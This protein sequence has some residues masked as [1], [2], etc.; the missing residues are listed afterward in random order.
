LVVVVTGFDV[1][2]REHEGRKPE[3]VKCGRREKRR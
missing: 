1:G 3:N 2:E